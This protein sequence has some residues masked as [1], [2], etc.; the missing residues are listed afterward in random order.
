MSHLA[1]RTPLLGAGLL[2]L[3]GAIAVAIMMAATSSASTRHTPSA[4]AASVS[5]TIRTRHTR[6]G[7]ILVSPSGDT[8][9]AFTRDSRNRD[10]CVSLR[11]C[12]SAWP[13]MAVRGT[14]RAGSGVSQ[15]MLGTIRVGSSRQVTYDG[16]PLYGYIGNSGPGDVSYVGA[17]AFGGDWLAVTPSAHLVR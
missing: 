12:R 4:S 14:L 10:T 5:T 13:I 17:R 11:G 6:I 7:T 3:L 1:R 16:H 15:S 9:Y 2:A 8:L